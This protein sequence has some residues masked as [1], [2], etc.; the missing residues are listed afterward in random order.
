MLLF[1]SAGCSYPGAWAMAKFGRRVVFFWTT[2]IVAVGTALGIGT[3]YL[4]E[5]DGKDP[6][7]PAF[8]MLLLSCFVVGF[9]QGIG[10]F[11]R[12]AVCEVC[13]PYPSSRAITMVIGGGVAAAFAGP[14]GSAATRYI[15]PGYDFAGSYY[16]MGLLVLINGVA[17]A[18]VDFSD[19]EAS[20]KN[21]DGALEEGDEEEYVESLGPVPAAA[22]EERKSL[23][24]IVTEPDILISIMM[25]TL[26]HTTML[27]LMGPIT[28]AMQDED[29]TLGDQS[30]FTTS[31]IV[32]MC[33]FLCMFSP[34]F[35]TGKLMQEAGELS[36][37]LAPRV[38]V[39]DSHTRLPILTPSLFTSPGPYVVSTLGGGIFIISTLVLLLGENL[40]N[41]WAGM[42]LCGVAWNFLFSAGTV[43]LTSLYETGD[44]IRVQGINDVLIFGVA[45]CGSFSSGFLYSW[46][47]WRMV[48][49]VA[50]VGV[51]L[52]LAMLAWLQ[53]RR[54]LRE[55]D[56]VAQYERDFPRMSHE[57]MSVSSQ[58]SMVL[59]DDAE[60]TPSS[61]RRGSPETR[62]PLISQ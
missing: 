33:H 23:W 28:L 45:G 8:I 22:P 18:Q 6:D 16:F 54:H 52:N 36:D 2:I 19:A 34:G 11:Y 39:R 24:K 20:K 47:G 55:L 10:Q 26:A 37:A 4:A 40:W 48:V 53:R 58:L 25:T 60:S 41:F 9:A 44:A 50:G 61:S 59:D 21:D 27:I 17:V 38:C 3:I 51:A 62:R 7:I 30:K 5:D 29:L 46:E 42:M 57:S 32:L 15:I 49:G 14:L 1:G 56:P 31:T 43:L 13:D 12:F 35:F